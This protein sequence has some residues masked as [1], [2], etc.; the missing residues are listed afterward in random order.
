M[1]RLGWHNQLTIVVSTVHGKR[2]VMPLEGAGGGGWM[3]WMPR[4][5]T[6]TGIRSAGCASFRRSDKTHTTWA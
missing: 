1:V 6:G 3:D 4:E 2:L 5:A